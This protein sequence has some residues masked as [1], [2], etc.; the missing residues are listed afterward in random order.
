MYHIIRGSV[1]RLLHHGKEREKIAKTQEL[2]LRTDEIVKFKEAH[3]KL[4]LRNGRD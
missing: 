3:E 4:F 1:K 2:C